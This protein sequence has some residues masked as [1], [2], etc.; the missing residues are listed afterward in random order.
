MPAVAMLII[1]F[2]LSYVGFLALEK[3]LQ[4]LID[5]DDNSALDTFLALVLTT[6]GF[7]RIAP[8]KLAAFIKTMSLPR[9]VT[10]TTGLKTADEV[11]DY[12][13][14][15]TAKQNGFKK[16]DAKL[17]GYAP[18]AV[19][20]S[21]K[22]QNLMSVKGTLKL[23]A[24]GAFISFLSWLIWAPAQLQNWLDQG[25]FAPEQANKIFEQLG[26]PYRWPISETREIATE[27]DKS[28]LEYY[29]GKSTGINGV[30]GFGRSGTMT[31]IRMS[32]DGEQKQF[33]GTLFSAK[34]GSV[35]HYERKVNDEIDNMEELRSDAQLAL[36]RWLTS[37]P[38]RM[39]YSINIAQEPVDEYGT[40]QSGIW[41]TLTLFVTHISGKTTPIDTILLG[42][43]SPKARIE[44][45]KFKR[46]IEGELPTAL[47]AQ[48]VR[49]IT[50]PNGT[51]DIFG[52]DGERVTP[53]TVTEVSQ[54]PRVDKPVDKPAVKEDENLKP[55]L[56]EKLA[57]LKSQLGDLFVKGNRLITD[58]PGSVLNLRSGAD[59]RKNVRAKVPDNTVLEIISDGVKEGQGGFFVHVVY[60]NPGAGK[61]MGYVSANYVRS[62]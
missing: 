14:N 24:A 5:R 10:A 52:E 20:L 29:Q 61:T 37:L 38:N 26:I 4:I 6:V 43:V 36:G 51:V 54:A 32:Q 60:D 39:G 3:L 34:I 7:K 2:L 25:V 22:L 15:L 55:E 47:T 44:L 13:V 46:E 18:L 45:G 57:D 30:T 58:T 11:A 1:R 59:T 49:E 56:K 27:L 21:K 31:I 50:I 12:F 42:P 53:S 23:G 19:A 48:Q 33:L 8:A 9:K 16:L 62:A 41:A 35:D 28:K 40:R 17:G